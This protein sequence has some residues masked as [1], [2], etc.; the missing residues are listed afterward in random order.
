MFTDVQCMCTVAKLYCG[1]MGDPLLQ[2]ATI[3]DGVLAEQMGFC[4]CLK[5]KACKL[6]LTSI[7]A[8]V[9]RP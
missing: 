2:L 6:W 4:R 5:L 7:T 1:Y 9:K 8:P 3:F